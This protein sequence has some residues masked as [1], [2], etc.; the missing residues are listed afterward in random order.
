LVYILVFGK[1]GPYFFGGIGLGKHREKK[2]HHILDLMQPGK[3]LNLGVIL[4]SLLHVI[5]FD[6]S[7]VGSQLFEAVRKAGIDLLEVIGNPN[8]IVQ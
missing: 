5:E 3:L 4:L 6:L 1:K 2:G 7:Q 8:G